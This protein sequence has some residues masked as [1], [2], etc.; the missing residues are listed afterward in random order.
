MRTAKWCKP[1]D[2]FGLSGH[3]AAPAQ[4]IHQQVTRTCGGHIQHIIR[5]NLEKAAAAMCAVA[6]GCDSKLIGVVHRLAR[7]P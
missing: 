3:G 7:V 5:P 6:I 4:V 2:C 1:P